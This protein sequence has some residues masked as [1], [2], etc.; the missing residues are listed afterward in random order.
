MKTV[1]ALFAFALAPL[2]AAAEVPLA[3]L[4]A[5]ITSI[6]SA[7]TAFLQTNADGSTAEGR[8]ILKRPY[9]MRFEYAPPDR[10]L[11]LASAS[12]VAVFDP[13]SNEPPAQ[14]PLRKTPLNL[15]LGRR[16]DLTTAN[17]VTAHGEEAGFTTV[18]AQD[19]EHPEYGS[20]K[21][22]FSADPIALRAWTVT[23]DTGTETHVELGD[24]AVG[25]DYPDS[26]FAI[27]AETERRLGD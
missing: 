19:P 23:D 5:Y 7:E 20:I 3:D 11:V 26:L 8:L 18:T 22:Y 4:S 21:L 2:P 16:I 17:M 25:G 12:T 10:T 14:Y 15:I 24:L 6:G 13:K 1:L 9:R 27:G